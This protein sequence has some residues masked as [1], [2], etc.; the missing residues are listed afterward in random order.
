[1]ASHVSQSMQRK[2]HVRHMVSHVFTC[3]S[4]EKSIKGEGNQFVEEERNK[5]E[6][7]EKKKK[8]KKG[9]EKVEEN[10]IGV[11]TVGTRRTKK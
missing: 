11:L 9:R 6:R 1:M 3:M 5:K 10:E 4:M 2:M 7:K 8:E